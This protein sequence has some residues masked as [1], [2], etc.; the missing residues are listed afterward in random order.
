MKLRNFIF[1]LIVCAVTATLVLGIAGAQA[2]A[3]STAPAKA[4]AKAAP[5]PRI[6]GNLAQVM[7]GILFPNSN[8]IFFV[9]GKDPAAVKPA[10]DPTTATDPLAGQ[11]GGWAAVENSGIALSESV[12]LI[13]MPGRLCSNGKPVPLSDPDFQKF[14]QELRTAGAAA[15]KAAQA[16]STEK[17]SDAADAVALACGD[18]HAKYRDVPGGVKDHCISSK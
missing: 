7:R 15:Y 5:A 11:F 12:T 10:E 14:A 4:P 18:C 13:T 17:V 6:S 1:T 3:G 9:Q 16:K 2:P 8:V